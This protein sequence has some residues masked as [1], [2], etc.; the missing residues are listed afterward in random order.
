MIP[1]ILGATAVGKTE[2]GMQICLKLNGEII[3]ADSRQIYRGMDIG[4]AKPTREQRTLVRHHLI[5]ILDPEQTFS[6]GDF[7]RQA[8]AAISDIQSR[9][10]L[11]VVV[12]GAGLYIRALTKGLFAGGASDPQLRQN[13]L[14]R[15]VHGG[16]E[17][18]WEE[19]R[20]LDPEYAEKVHLNDRKKTARFFEIYLSTG[21]TVSQ[22]K[23]HQST[24]SFDSVLIGIQLDRKELYRRIEQRVERMI[25]SGLLEEVE[26]LKAKGYD[27]TLNSMNSPG[28]KEIF[29]YLEGKSSWETAVELIKR[30]TRRYAK[31]QIT[32]F[33]KDE[34]HW[35]Q[36]HQIDDIISLIQSCLSPKF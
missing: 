10:R 32:W 6:A 34:V 2:I 18:M 1:V 14:H 36:P 15:Y 31:R 8:S 5:D 3:S 7:V 12:G 16:K 22:L 20:L 28:Y 26:Q 17:K 19:L 9:G 29:D 25:V 30:N 33:K 24:A 4:S 35:F 11:P 21:L 27:A 23:N 13:L